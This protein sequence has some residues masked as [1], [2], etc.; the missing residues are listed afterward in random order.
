MLDPKDFSFDPQR[1]NWTALTPEAALEAI[2]GDEL[3]TYDLRA[4]YETLVRETKRPL[5]LIEY[6]SKYLM[7]S[8]D[9]ER[10]SALR[11]MAANRF[12]ATAQ[13]VLSARENAVAQ[14]VSR[15]QTPGQFDLISDSIRPAALDVMFALAGVGTEIIA[16]DLIS[17][18]RSIGRL[19]RIEA[20]LQAMHDYVQFH[21]SQE[22]ADAKAMRIVLS[23]VGYEPLTAGL[24]INVM[25]LLLNNPG[26][27]LC[28]IN[29][30]R[31]FQTAP[32]RNV[33]RMAPADSS[34]AQCPMRSVRVDTQVFLADPNNSYPSALFGRG[35]HSCMGR[36]ITM[37]MW[38]SLIEGLSQLPSRVEIVDY[39]APDHW[40]FNVPIKAELQVVV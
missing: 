18:S 5:P 32:V 30:P 4:Y 15:F 33:G 8:A 17:P 2:A 39:Q 24:S 26:K 9:G 38:G 28:D 36:G 34:P 6:Y 14:I 12:S 35:K 27:R 1:Q 16:S 23:L 22:D 7:L 13:D 10:H 25:T 19:R 31:E 11:K 29:W 20:E 3:R 37:M 21:Y 40:L